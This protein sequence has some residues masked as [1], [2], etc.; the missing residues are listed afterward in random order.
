MDTSWKRLLL[1]MPPQQG[2]LNGFAGGLISLANFAGDRLCQLQTD[3]LDL[4]RHTLG[5]SEPLIR[6]A[7][8]ETSGSRLFVG[9]TTTTASYQSALQ[10]AGQVRGLASDAVVIFGGSHAS[11]DPETILR[12][13]Q[14]LVSVIVVGEGE[15]PLADLVQLYPHHTDVPG[16][17]YIDQHGGF[18][19]NSP[20]PPLTVAELDAIP[21]T[22]GDNGLIGTPGKF[23]HATYVSARGCPR[24]CAFCSV[25]H[26]RIRAKSVSVVAREIEA[27]LDMGFPRIAI[28]DNF[29]AHSYRRTKEICDA[30]ADI[31][32]RTN[33]LFAWDCQTR[34][35]SL[36]RKDSIALLAKAGCEAVY[37]GVESVHA[38]QLKY[39]NKTSHPSRYL[40]LLGDVVV[41][42]LLDAGIECYLN[43]QFGLPGETEEHERVTC[44]VLAS[45]GRTAA[46]CGKT[47][48]IFPQLHVVYPGTAHFD[49]GVAEGRFPRA[50]FEAFTEWEFRQA[51]VLYWLGEHFGHGTGGIPAGILKADVLRTGNFEDVDE[52][53]DAKAVF[54]ISAALRAIDRIKG[55]RTFNYGDY[56][57]TDSNLTDNA[58]S[59]SDAAGKNRRG[60]G[61]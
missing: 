2:L 40:H 42:A 8:Q 31:T 33:G 60:V 47:I 45:L 14:N 61:R 39:L 9:I 6:K 5:H 37:V 53:V 15:K 41:P 28:E 26:D 34:V 54:R 3:I 44:A 27:L 32:L 13:H 10:I 49:E 43:L 57:V 1:I 59:R 19:R 18:V 30:L 46:D 48:T 51:P 52:V 12:R 11:A 16:I 58:A 25:G 7:I 36:A 38:R 22:Y 23:D 20:P 56:I 35:E 21:I 17:A 29:F 4:S 55:V 50:V 24:S